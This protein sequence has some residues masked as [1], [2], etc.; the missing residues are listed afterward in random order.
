MSKKKVLMCYHSSQFGGVEKHILDLIEGLSAVFDIFVVCPNGPLVE[1]YLKAGAKKHYEFSPVFEADFSYSLKIKKIIEDEKI[2]V[3]HSHELLTGSLATFGGWLARCDKRIYH[4]HTSF[5]QWRYSS[6]KK[7][8][9][10]FINTIVNFIVGNFFATDVIALTE[11]VKRIRTRKE[12]INPKKIRVI[13]NGIQLELF[14]SNKAEGQEYRQRLGIL[15]GDFVI[16]NIARFT[17]EKGHSVLIDAFDLL[18]KADKKFNYHLVLA[19][20]GILQNDMQLKVQELGIQDKVHF[21]GSFSDSDKSIIL[22]SFDCF[23]FPSFA[24]GFGIALVE[25]MAIGVP[26]IAS[27]LDVL[28]DV[29]GDTINYFQYGDSVSLENEIISISESIKDSSIDVKPE[30]SRARN[31]SMQNFWREYSN[32]YS[33]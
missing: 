29:G 22:S 12:F 11:S 6:F 8:F 32:L 18:L 27:N 3:L 30:I 7:Y 26:I 16:G 21:V 20:T 13:P 28:K 33:S 25:A 17:E 19:G 23:V 15:E 4:V 24:E 5:T 2:D 1:E 31:F 10:L 14:K 9:A